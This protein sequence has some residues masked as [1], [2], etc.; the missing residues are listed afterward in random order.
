MKTKF[1]TKWIP[2]ITLI[3]T[4]TTSQNDV[5]ASHSEGADITYKCLGGN[6]Y[7]LTLS[8]Y[9]DC[10]GV[11]APTAPT[12]NCASLSSGQNFNITLQPIPGTGQE[13]SLVCANLL[14]ECQGGT[15]PGVQ[16]WVYKG[17][18][19]ITPATDWIF[20]FD[21]CCRNAAITTIVNPGGQN[22]HIESTLDNLNFPCNSSPIFTTK[23]IPFVCLYQNYTFNHGANDPDG[24]FITYELV[25]P[26][27]GY[28]GSTIIYLPPYTATQPLSTNPAMQFDTITG[29][30]NM[31]PTMLEVTVLAVK[32]KKWR[33]NQL[34]GYVIRDI[35]LRTMN[36]N[37]SYPFINGINGTG[38]Y[39]TTACAGNPISFNIYTSDPDSTQTVTLTW[40]NGISNATFTVSGGQFPTGTFSWTPTMSDIGTHCFTLTITDNNCPINGSLT[41]AI[42]LVV[43]GVNVNAIST[44][45]N[46]GLNNGSAM[47]TASSGTPPYTYQWFPCGCTTNS[48]SGL[49]SGTYTVMV[50]DSKGCMGMDT[51]SVNNGFLPASLNLTSTPVSCFGGNNS[52]ATA[53][54]T[55][56][57]SPY[58]YIWSN[59][60]TT[61]T[62]TNLP[63]GNYSVSVTTANG[64]V[65]SDS[66]LISQPAQLSA[67]VSQQDV[68]C[69]GMSNGTA[70]VVAAGGSAPY[71]YS[72]NTGQTTQTITGVAS[73]NYFVTV[74]D[75]NG[76]T[77]IQNVFIN[78][79]AQIALS[80]FS[81]TNVSCNGGSN[82]TAT[83]ITYGGIPP[84]SYMWNNGQ[85]L[86]T[87]TGLS[88]GNY[89][90]TVLDSAG[91]T[92]I[93]SINISQPSPLASSITSIPAQCFGTNNGTAIAA[94]AGGSPSYTY[95]WSNGQTTSVSSNLIAGNYS[96]IVTDANGCSITDSVTI[97]QPALLTS[98][99]SSVQN[100]S[101][102]H[103]SNG[104]A[105][106]AA[107]GGTSPYTYAWS[108]GQTTSSVSFLSGGNYSVTITDANG[109]SAVDTIT[110]T[111]PDAI[112]VTTSPDDTICPGNIFTISAS[113][114]GGT[115]PFTYFWLPNVGFGS[116]QAVN[117]GVT[118]TYTV[119][120]TDAN[121]CTSTGT[122]TI[123]VYGMN[124]SVTLNATPSICIGQTA[125]LS[126]SV[127]GNNATNY[128]WSNNLGNGAG[129]FTV[130]PTI[131]TT[132][133]VIVTNVCGAT[134]AAIA[135]VV[136]HPLPLINLAPQNETGCDAVTL[137]FSD[138]NS[139]NNGS[140]YNWSF[141][142]GTH[143]A[144][145]VPSH[146][147]TESG[148]YNVNVVVTSPYGC[149]AAAQT[150]CTVGIIA[151]PDANFISDPPLETSILQPDFRFFDKSINATQWLWDFGD[152]TNSTQQ[153]PH[154]IYAQTGIY[155]VKLVT[156]NA[157]MCVDSIIKTIE[158]KPEFT[159]YVPNTFSPNGDHINDVF[160]GKGMEI[161]EYEM[162]IFDRWGN[163][164]FKTNDLN[165]GWDGR[166]YPVGLLSNGANEGVEIAQQ[167][168]YV[169]KIQLRDFSGKSHYY[170]GQVNLIK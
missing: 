156:L 9:R 78:Q 103:G 130:S 19:T 81:L 91:C 15:Y 106:A 55:G 64:C 128:Y 114:S 162:L 113:T 112:L 116:A 80:I 54:A 74:T 51:V 63:A 25:T 152:E 94:A 119:I 6:Q 167:D 164:I 39:M 61:S 150:F 168:V 79:P 124:M 45:A 67:S 87:A 132:Y 42:C 76:C 100:V 10:H 102:N 58:T 38:A 72:W 96:V 36:C 35:Q 121:G 62:A 110:I 145:A 143:S 14:T 83:A 17:I 105:A 118:T 89:I 115:S 98:T 138:T 75:A 149:S 18:V 57:Q 85:T 111:Q 2:L 26:M 27:N 146:T 101:C 95:L 41:Y 52:S 84:Y 139:S 99:I 3:G 86:Q 134:A 59:G 16:E 11:N 131:T 161:T 71:S 170:N 31:K 1:F 24:D 127:S 29:D 166:V 129:P 21:Y 56:G 65:T 23:P 82:G 50:T 44:N 151:S 140:T 53:N 117:P 73:G 4:L 70:S 120:I 37:N 40:N 142:D 158:V 160:S 107:G 34:V 137:Q 33:N 47:A 68:T 92:S 32:V 165:I 136:V 8:F 93:T 22:I 157:G 169:Y 60:Q 123:Y 148:S 122:T 66:V 125:T 49:P 135:T 28:S 46:C 108:N 12:I 5:F 141:G 43:Y 163:Q 77:S 155:T 13:I 97:S 154:H 104:S 20:S 30:L 153:N 147:Y 109:C 126:A 7:E 90:V 48:I 133:S 144:S 69:F 88:A 159:F